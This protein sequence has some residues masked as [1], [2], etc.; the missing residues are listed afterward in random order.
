MKRVDASNRKDWRKWLEDNHLKEK[1]V[2]LVI[3][4]KHTGKPSLSHRE[5]M[6]DAI[7]FGWID[8][9]LKRLDDE[10][11]LRRFARRNDKSK[12]SNNTLNYAKRLLTEG[13]MSPEG[14]KRYREGLSRPTHDHGLSKNPSIPDDLEMALKKEKLLD[15]FV[16]LAP[17]YRRMQLRWIERAKRKET[18][19]KRIREIVKMI[20]IGKKMIN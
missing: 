15:K 7:C 11:Y 8:T 1:N 14:I 19:D 13:Q 2:E 10:K 9:T 6:E 12:W 3:Y 20:Q 5:S 17:S 16:A 18:R 4:K